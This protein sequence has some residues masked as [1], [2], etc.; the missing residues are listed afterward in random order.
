MFGFQSRIMHISKDIYDDDNNVI[1][2]I[3]QA[4]V[5]ITLALEWTFNV[6]KFKIIGK[7]LPKSYL[8][9]IL[10][11]SIIVYVA[12]VIVHDFQIKD[13]L[14]SIALD[15]EIAFIDLCD[16]FN[17]DGMLPIF[18]HPFNSLFFNHNVSNVPL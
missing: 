18:V 15:H 17:K 12:N 8:N 7:N 16:L 3:Y 4:L 13:K 11:L 5:N 6:R 9:T 2:S 10:M 14:I 1:R